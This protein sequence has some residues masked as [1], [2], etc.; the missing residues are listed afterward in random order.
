M[1]L[2]LTGSTEQ[3]NEV[4]WHSP[5]RQLFLV[6]AGGNSKTQVNNRS[7]FNLFWAVPPKVPSRTLSP[8][9]SSLIYNKLGSFSYVWFTLGEIR[10]G[11]VGYRALCSL[12]TLWECNKLSITWPH[13]TILGIC[14][15]KCLKSHLCQYFGGVDFI[16]W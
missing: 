5:P 13:L 15:K 14:F 2:G 8:L 6:W 4:W 16:V 1:Q 11:Y 9:P 7:S 10:L 12:S 3:Q